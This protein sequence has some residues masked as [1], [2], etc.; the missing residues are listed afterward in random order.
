MTM[1]PNNRSRFWG[2]T[3]LFTT[4]ATL[5]CCALPILLVSLG[6]GAAVASIASAAPWLIQLSLY[7][8]WVFAV[9]GGLVLLAAWSVMR[10]GR[11]CPVDPE[12]AKACEAADKWNKRFVLLSAVLWC[13]GFIAAY[14]PALVQYLL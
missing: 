10:S 6:L 4:S 11:S 3:L 12:L 7:K 2:W 8:A 14:I 5:V 1:K 13:I 9:S